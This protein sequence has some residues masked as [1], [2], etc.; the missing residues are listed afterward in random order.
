M[1]VRRK[2][3]VDKFYVRNAEIL[4]SKAAAKVVFDDMFNM[5]VESLMAGDT[6][7]VTG[8][9]RFWVSHLKPRPVRN[10]VEKTTH[11]GIAKDAV[12]FTTSQVV[13][14]RINAGK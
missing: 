3:L 2:D 11:M 4:K 9:G 10:P 13:Q 6:V 14:N 1:D 7:V 8:F 12:R 5:I